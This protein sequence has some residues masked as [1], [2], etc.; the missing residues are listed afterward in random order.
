MQHPGPQ[1]AYEKSA[2]R[3]GRDHKYVEVMKENMAAQQNF[4][5]NQL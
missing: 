5:Q 1:L 3:G 4:L 2:G